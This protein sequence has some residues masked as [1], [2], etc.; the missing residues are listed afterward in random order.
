MSEEEEEEEYVEEE[1]EYVEE[2]E[3]DVKWKLQYN[4]ICCSMTQV[5]KLFLTYHRG[6]MDFQQFPRKK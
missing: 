1:E 3:E 4:K 2:E 6:C 5:Q